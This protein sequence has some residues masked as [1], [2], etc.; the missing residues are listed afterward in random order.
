MNFKKLSMA[1]ALGLFTIVAPART[2]EA[3]W[4]ANLIGTAEYDTDNT[5]LLLAGISAGPRGLGWAPRIGVQ[6]YYLRFDRTAT[7]T[8]SVTAIRPYVGMRNAF[9]G[10]S[11]GINV[12]YAFVDRDVIGGTGV[13]PAFVE[14][15]ADGVVLSGGWDYWGTGDSFGYQLLGS[16]SF[17]SDAIWT[18]ARGTIPMTKGA[19]SQTRIGAEV[20]FLSGDDYSAW[21][22][23]AVLEF[24]NRAGR[25]FGLGAGMKFFEGGDDAVY[26]KAEVSMPLF[27]R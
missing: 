22:P 14:D 19:N 26:F 23:G 15:H 4:G 8:A 9:N 5:M 25:V 18:R 21:Q 24:N 3:Q 20:A 17:A 16:Y 6:G 13:I 12:G 7:T 11:A 1:I 27:R 2:A 10:G